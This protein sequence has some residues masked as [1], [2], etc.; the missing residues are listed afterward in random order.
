M[1][2]PWTQYLTIIL[3][4]SSVS[5]LD[6]NQKTSTSATTSQSSPEEQDPKVEQKT[7]PE[8][9]DTASTV[10][11]KTEDLEKTKLEENY[12]KEGKETLGMSGVLC[13]CKFFLV[14]CC[15]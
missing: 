1:E 8:P 15:V 10:D 6:L 5:L 11:Q 4:D 2:D 12:T 9:L 14:F 7:V 3:L 13:C